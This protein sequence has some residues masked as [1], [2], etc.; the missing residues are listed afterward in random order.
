MPGMILK[1]GT[2]LHYEDRGRGPAVV[3]SHGWLLS[4]D[5]WECQ[6]TFL[7]ERGY[8]VVA[9]DRRGSGRSGQTGGGF[10]YEQFADDL[11]EL[12]DTLGLDDIVLVGFSMGGGEVARYIGRHGTDL[13]R[14]VALL[15]AITPRLSWAEDFPEGLPPSVFASVHAGIMEDRAEFF[16]GLGRLFF[17][18]EREGAVISDGM[19]AQYH[20]MAMQASLKG[21]LDSVIA[22]SETDFRPDLAKFDVPTL[23]IHGDDDSLVPLDASARKAVA[24]VSD[25]RLIV[26]EGASHGLTF[27]HKDRLN[28]DLLNFLQ[29]R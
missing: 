19:L 8:R 20:E 29:A 14:K 26:Y 10:N 7:T 16:R 3:F 28:A 18:A 6:M 17:G 13:V 2:R 25:A 12:I 21:A 15:G 1:D 11:A 27:T 23:F 5:M 4:A 9:H 24:L 22:F